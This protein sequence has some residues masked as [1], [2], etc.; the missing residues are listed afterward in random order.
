VC[1][2]LAALLAKYGWVESSTRVAG[3]AAN[4]RDFTELAEGRAILELIGGSGSIWEHPPFDSYAPI[5]SDGTRERD[6]VE[7]QLDFA[8]FLE[9]L[10]QIAEDLVTQPAGSPWAQRYLDYLQHLQ[11]RRPQYIWREPRDD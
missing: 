4:A 6:S 7:E 2:E 9:L 1:D 5:H 3:L 11:A 8:R 10:R